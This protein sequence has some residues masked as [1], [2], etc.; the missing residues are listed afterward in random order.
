[1]SVVTESKRSDS[2]ANGEKNHNSRARQR[3]LG[4]ELERFYRD[5]VQEPVPQT[6]LELIRHFDDNHGADGGEKRNEVS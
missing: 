1:V 2:S 5:L 4:R 3:A 6:F